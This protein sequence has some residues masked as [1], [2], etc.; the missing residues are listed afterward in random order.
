MP[1]PV[2]QAHMHINMTCKLARPLLLRSPRPW[3]RSQDAQRGPSRAERRPGALGVHKAVCLP[4]A[5]RA[6]SLDAPP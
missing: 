4:A 6:P 1:L 2:Q 5:S 3:R